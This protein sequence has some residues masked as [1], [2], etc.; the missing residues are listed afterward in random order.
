MRLRIAL[1]LPLLALMLPL[2][3]AAQTAGQ[4]AVQPGQ[5]GWREYSPSQRYQALKN[6]QQHNKLPDDRREKVEQNYER[7]RAMPESERER[8]RKN[9]QRFQKLPPDQ[10]HKLTERYRNQPK[11][12]PGP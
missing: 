3:V 11:H 4:G 10:R 8:M 7:W 9:Y 2:T 12:P 1:S 6:Y 5:P